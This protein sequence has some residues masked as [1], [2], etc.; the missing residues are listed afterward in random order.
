MNCPICQEGEI[1]ENERTYYC[2]NRKYN[3]ELEE[4]EGCG[5][6]I[7]KKAFGADVTKEDLESLIEGETIQKTCISSKGSE[8]EGLFTLDD[9]FKIK[10]S[11][12]ERKEREA[13]KNGIIDIGKGYKKDDIVVWKTIAGKEISYDQAV[14]LLNGGRITFDDFKS[15]QG[16][17]FKA[18]LVLNQEENKIDM[19]FD[20]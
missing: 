11:F 19:V 14:E 6:Q 2:S 17:D 20:N 12:P 1:K 3:K 9:E 10:L 16:E 15:R 7:W 18:T 13:D 4:N 5:F 8:Y